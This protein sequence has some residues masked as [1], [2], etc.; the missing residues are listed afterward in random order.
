MVDIQQ[1]NVG[2]YS[3]LG[4]RLYLSHYPIHLLMS[5]RSI[6]VQQMFDINY[7]QKPECA[8]CMCE[9]GTN[10]IELLNKKVIAMNQTARDKGVMLHMTVKEA[11]YLC[12]A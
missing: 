9:K 2:K 3:F 10:C 12:E 4:I 5:T 11:L 6:I 1:V 7:F 8:V